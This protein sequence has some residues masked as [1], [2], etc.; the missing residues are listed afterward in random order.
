MIYESLCYAMLAGYSSQMQRPKLIMSAFELPP[1]PS[2]CGRPLWMVPNL[3]NTYTSC[4]WICRLCICAKVALE[5]FP[6][7]EILFLLLFTTSAS[8]CMQHSH[9]KP[10]INSFDHTCIIIT[11]VIWPWWCY[12]SCSS[13]VMHKMAFVHLA[14]ML[15]SFPL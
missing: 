11:W 3:G 6:G 13:H 8:T 2:K 9:N 14:L 1:S 12:L 4:P 5:S 7:L 10:G 15:M